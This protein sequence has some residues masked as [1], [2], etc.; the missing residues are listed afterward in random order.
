MLA[1]PLRQ[2]LRRPLVIITILVYSNEI[3][4]F[5][6]FEVNFMRLMD[7]NKRQF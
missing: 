2:I 5:Y 1:K 4:V 7:S 6:M 3:I